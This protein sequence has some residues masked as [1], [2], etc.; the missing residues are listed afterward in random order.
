M[1]R[2]ML[3]VIANKWKTKHPGNNPIVNCRLDKYTVMNSWT[4]ILYTALEMNE[5]AA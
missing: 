3:A 2:A 5:Y 4:R 1:I